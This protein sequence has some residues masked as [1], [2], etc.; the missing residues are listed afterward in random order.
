MHEDVQVSDTLV[1]SEPRNLFALE[2]DASKYL[3]FSGGIGITPILAMA[4]TLA[5]AGR[6]FE[7]PY[8]SRSI[9]RA[10]FLHLLMD[11]PFAHRVHFHFDDGAPGRSSTS[12]R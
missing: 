6:N 12:A 11:T 2:P 7:L 9:A 10:A 1:I 3:L 8:R 5:Q 4:Y